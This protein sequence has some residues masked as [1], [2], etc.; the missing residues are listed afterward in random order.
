MA[1]NRKPVGVR[2]TH[3]GAEMAA[4][5]PGLS[6]KDSDEWGS[7]AD[8][9]KSIEGTNQSRAAKAKGPPSPQARMPPLTENIEA[10]GMS[11]LMELQRGQGMQQLNSLLR[12][13]D[14]MC[15]LQRQNSKLREQAEYL[16]AVKNLHELRN[17]TMRQNCHCEGHRRASD[18][19]SSSGSRFETTHMTGESLSEPESQIGDDLEDITGRG[20]KRGRSSKRDGKNK[21]MKKRSRSLDPFG[22]E[23]E[24]KDRS[25]QGIF[26]KI[27]KMKEKLSN[28]RTSVKRRSNSRGEGSKSDEEGED[29][30]P[31]PVFHVDGLETKSEDSGIFHIG[32][33]DMAAAA[34]LEAFMQKSIDD[35][36]DNED[37]FQGT[38]PPTW[39]RTAVL[40]QS[41]RKGS[42]LSSSSEDYLE[43]KPK[44]TS[45]GEDRKQSSNAAQDSDDLSSKRSRFRRVATCPDTATFDT[46]DPEKAGQRS[47]GP[48]EERLKQKR[49][50]HQSH[51]LDIEMT[52]ASGASERESGRMSGSEFKQPQKRKYFRK[53]QTAELD[54]HS[55]SSVSMEGTFKDVRSPKASPPEKKKHKGEFVLLAIFLL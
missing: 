53:S 49:L 7:I 21:S 13:M 54:D 33:E 46:A 3:S 27:E 4:F 31:G 25:K 16:A 2:G 6:H 36:S 43:S 19:S 17:E 29:G 1:E 9:L 44:R 14:Q 51:S 42:D 10:S 30:K 47:M 45:P 35:L 18:L 20:A 41:R 23:N 34:R 39:A 48:V 11:Q 55:S 26:S 50:Q 52:D 12:L 40:A 24:S 8:L 15:A 38:V 22:D 32:P 37:I 5:P 28:R